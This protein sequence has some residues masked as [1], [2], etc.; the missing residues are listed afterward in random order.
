MRFFTLFVGVHSMSDTPYK[1]PYDPRIHNFGN[2]GLG[3][4]IHA[5]LARPITKII[6][7]AAYDGEDVRTQIV[8]TLKCDAKTISDWCCGTGMST[9]ALRSKF[10]NAAIVA[11]D[12]S[13]EMLE[14][15]KKFS[16]A[17]FILGD[18]ENVRLSIPADLITIFFAFHEI[19]QHGRLKILKNARDNLAEGGKLLVVDIDMDYTPSKMML[20][21]EPYVMDYLANVREDFKMVFPSVKENV[22]VPGHVCQWIMPK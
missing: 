22:I 3:G 7:H 8:N 16:D 9:D 14:V 5:N 20:S 13:Q 1:Y 2:V 17:T 18:V 11:V 21:G 15:A 19:P 4:K 12:T 6:D 10:K